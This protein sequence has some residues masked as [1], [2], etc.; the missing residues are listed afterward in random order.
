M[1]R[2]MSSALALDQK[3]RKTSLCLKVG[4]AV[5][6]V[7]S[8]SVLKFKTAPAYVVWSDECVLKALVAR[9]RGEI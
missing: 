4:N 3:C 2:T 9:V 7:P 1:I 5:P 8:L 6:H